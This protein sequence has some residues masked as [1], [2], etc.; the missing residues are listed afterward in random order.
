[1]WNE[2]APLELLKNMPHVLTQENLD[3]IQKVID[4]DKYIN[5]MQLGRDLCGEY[6]PFCATCKKVGW[7]PCAIAY[8]NMK[9]ADGEDV[10]ISEECVPH[11]EETEAPAPEEACIKP[12]VLEA[13]AYEKPLQIQTEE[14]LRIEE[15]ATSSKEQ[16]TGK[17][18]IAVARRRTKS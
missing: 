8:V 7:T 10:E 4:E 16:K 13:L 15:T 2:N 12:P 17:I 18:R 3:K 9:I 5:S 14:K 11:C 1:M 6:A